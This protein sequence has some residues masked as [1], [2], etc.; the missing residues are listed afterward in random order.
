MKLKTLVFCAVLAASAL[1]YAAPAKSSKPNFVFFLVDDFGWASISSMG[2]EFL[3]TPNIDKLVK[4]G[5]QFTNGYAACTVCS[6]S[7]AA[8]LTGAYPGRT[9][10]TDW[11]PG[12]NK[13]I[14]KLLIPDWQKY[15]DHERI[16]L[17]E[18][19]K[20]NGYST[21]FIGKWHLLSR[22][23]PTTNTLSRGPWF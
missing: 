3:E 22:S 1:S 14:R 10:L 15:M 2:D 17:P 9:K 5:M 11:I 4:S 12:H 21:N 19:L 18:A 23:A 6:P 16:L 8:I 13:Y 7:R 20:E